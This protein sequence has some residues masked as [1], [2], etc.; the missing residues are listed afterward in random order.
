MSVNVQRSSAEVVGELLVE[1]QRIVVDYPVGVERT[2]TTIAD[3][4]AGTS[5]FP[6]G[7]GLWRGDFSGGPIPECFPDSPVMFVGHN[8]D[9][10]AK[11]KRAIHN[12][13]EV[14]KSFWQTLIG[15]I[16]TSGIDPEGCFFTN[17]LMGL[18]PDKAS[19]PMPPSPAHREQCQRFLMRQVEIVGPRAVILLGGDAEDQWN[20]ARGRFG[21]AQSVRCTRIMHP[22]ARPR[23]W[24][25][26]RA[27]WIAA[28][29]SE[30]RACIQHS[31]DAIE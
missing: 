29:G 12:R 28:Q 6:G 21:I 4:I 30:I 24:R 13:G 26:D 19:G 25:A 20:R 31:G 16:A 8:F 5:F 11:Y 14:Q 23:N 27:S 7:T 3:L 10:V 15:F 17:A 1:M 22:S 2:G 9:I 18:Q